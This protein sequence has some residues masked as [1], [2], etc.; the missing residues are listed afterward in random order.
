MGTNYN[1]YPANDSPVLH[2][3]KSSGGWC[4]SLHVTAEITSLEDW[5]R[6]FLFPGHIESEYVERI[7]VPEMLH[8]ITERR[9]AHPITDA[10]LCDHQRHGD[11]IR[12]PNGLLRHGINQWCCGHGPGTWDLMP[13]DFS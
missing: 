10:E 3:G 5:K 7:P 12:G 13:G 4:F 9:L 11:V 1:W 8:I 6:V 2:I